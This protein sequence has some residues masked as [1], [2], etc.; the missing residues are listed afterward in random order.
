MLEVPA[1]PALGAAQIVDRPGAVQTNIRLAGPAVPPGHE[2]AYALDVANAIFGGSGGSRLV[3]NIR[4]DKGYTYSP[5]SA[6]Q[7]FRRASIFEVSAE[8]STDV[9]APALV[10]TRYELGKM[11]ALEV[12]ASELEG[13]KRYLSG[14]MSIRIQSQRG[15]AAML[16]RLAVFG[17]DIEYLKAY[18]RRI[19]S[20]NA[21]DVRAASMDYLAPGRLVTLLVGDAS[22]IA[23]EIEALEPLEIVRA[24]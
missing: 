15:L 9:T 1:T 22:R 3:R 16:A 8:V 13:A 2:D 19:M 17:L 10:E 24:V 7:H 20:V 6:V 12:E 18:P 23:R 11:A 4:E 21:A 14:L 5:H